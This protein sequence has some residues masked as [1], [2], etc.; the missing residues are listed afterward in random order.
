MILT[1]Y[2]KYLDADAELKRIFG[3][4]AISGK[5]ISFPSSLI[6]VF[7]FHIFEKLENSRSRNVESKSSAAAEASCAFASWCYYKSLGR[8]GDDQFFF[9][10]AISFKIL[11]ILTKDI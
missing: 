9:I 8:D 5:F 10:S 6:F 2:S 3:S 7:F 4:A 1:P 11:K